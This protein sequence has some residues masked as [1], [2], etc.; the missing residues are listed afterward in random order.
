MPSHF[1]D[2]KF[3]EG[4]LTKLQIFELY[5]Q[6]WL[7]VFLSR[8]K[9]KWSEVHIFDF[10]AGPG[11]DAAGEFGSPLRI[12]RQINSFRSLAG[13]ERV[14]LTVHFFDESARKLEK[15]KANIEANGL[16]IS[17]VK[18]DI[19][20]LPFSSAFERVKNIM[21]SN[22][23]AKL[24]FADQF[25]V[26]QITDEVFQQ[27]VKFPTCDFLFF[28]SSSTLHRFR[29]HPAIR[30]KIER[31]DDYYHVHHAVLEYY[32]GLLPK[33]WQYYLA[34]FSIKKG[35]NIYGIIFGSGH[36][37]GMDKFLRVAWNTD[38]LNGEA[39][40][41]IHRDDILPG[42]ML[43]P[44]DGFRPSKVTAF[45]H[46]LE[47]TI[48]EGKC[49]TELEVIWK[50]FDHGVTRKH[51]ETL[52]AKLKKEGVIT[53]DFRVPDIDRLRQPKPIHLT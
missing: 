32:R 23:A 19:E 24:V 18:F 47:K 38:Q 8:D 52:L 44:I 26:D 28:I 15:L 48:R 25:G 42:E 14:Q 20:P 17:G 6:E 16:K 5:L 41:D 53:F 36:P 13:F 2:K 7:P 1:H 30:L 34:P 12:L 37:L 46:D 10:F 50:C 21:V 49:P 4:T 39:D 31:P 33:D 45:E 43:L 22:S 27:L 51:A 11:T 3:D 40:F 35:S 29:E 9:P